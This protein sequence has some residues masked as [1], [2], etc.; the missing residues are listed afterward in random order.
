MAAKKKK[1]PVLLPAWLVCPACF[2]SLPLALWGQH[3]TTWPGPASR[4]C[5]VSASYPHQDQPLLVSGASPFTARLGVLEGV[6][7]RGKSSAGKTVTCRQDC[8]QFWVTETEFKFHVGVIFL[9]NAPS[10]CETQRTRL[11]KTWW[12]QLAWASVLLNWWFPCFL[13]V[14]LRGKCS[15]CTL[16]LKSTQF[17]RVWTLWRCRPHLFTQTFRKWQSK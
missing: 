8:S 3:A 2:S 9:S 17:L 10:R 15:Q 11:C 7:Y 14:A 12:V 1:I 4:L 13:L 16:A 5:V 6:S